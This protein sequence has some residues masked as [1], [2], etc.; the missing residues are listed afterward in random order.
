MHQHLT[1]NH[2]GRGRE[3]GGSEAKDLT[4]E[5]LPWVRNEAAMDGPPKILKKMTILSIYLGRFPQF[6]G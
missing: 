6:G 2:P 1:P 5:M 4:L 3:S